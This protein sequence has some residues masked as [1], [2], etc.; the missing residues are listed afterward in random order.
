MSTPHHALIIGKFYPPHAGHHL[1]ID[2]AAASCARV[3]VVA[4]AATQ[5]SIALSSRVQWLRQVHAHQAHVHVTGIM[6]DVRMDLHDPDI[7]HA[8]VALMRE[9]LHRIDAP[10][11][12]A[13]FSSEPYG[14]ELARR[15]HARAVTL[16]PARTLAPIS[17]TRLR[18]DLAAHWDFLAPPV[19]A[20]LAHRVVVVGAESTGTT[21]LSRALCEALRSRGGVHGA[22]RWVPEHGRDWTMR[23]L[24]AARAQA[25]LAPTPLPPP[26]MED[27]QWRSEEFSAIARQQIQL[28]AREAA[29][30]GPLLVC[31]TDALATTLWHH[32]YVGTHSLEVEAIARDDPGALYLLTSPDDVPF[33]QDG[34][35][36]GESIR[37]AMHQQFLQTLQAGGH[38]WQL[39]RGSHAQRL[40]QALSAVD[41]LLAC[42]WHLS[43]PIGDGSTPSA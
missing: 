23:K 1:L 20:A 39:M 9:A 33:E 30:G 10:P 31:D 19:K 15:F 42:G 5:E 34:L 38:R 28:A 37:H 29:L 3:S 18:A 14:Q 13:V 40:R 12:T 43:A 2:S 6:D 4:M 27:L 17:A 25:Q 21:T 22:T 8:H 26:R 11:V 16:D 32:R 24:A 36:D 7:W 35:R 41:T